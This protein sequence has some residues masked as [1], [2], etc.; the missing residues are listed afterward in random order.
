MHH[1]RNPPLHRRRVA[2]DHN[3]ALARVVVSSSGLIYQSALKEFL[4]RPFPQSCIN[5]DQWVA[6]THLS[7]SIRES[8]VRGWG[9]SRKVSGESTKLHTPRKNPARFYRYK[10]I[11]LGSGMSVPRRGFSDVR[12]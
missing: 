5:P 8:R 11:S 4:G 3:E 10:H 7:Q 1:L 9:G 2:E 6:R 12:K